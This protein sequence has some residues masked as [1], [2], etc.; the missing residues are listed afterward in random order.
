MKC[1]RCGNEF[2]PV[3][4]QQYCHF[5][6]AGLHDT[7]APNEP[8]WDNGNF[9]DEEMK[10]ELE[11]GFA[12]SSSGYCPWEDQEKLGFL[13]GFYLTLKE[14]LFEAKE[15]FSAMPRSNGFLLPLL[16]ALIIQT[17]GV[18]FTFFWAFV[19]ENPILEKV[20]LTGNH[21]ILAALAFPVILFLLVFIMAVLLHVSLIIVGGVK[22]DFEATF[23]VSCYSS[24]PE[25]FNLIPIIGGFI[26][27]F[28]KIYITV[29]GLRE[30]HGTSSGKAIVA[31]LLTLFICCGISF[32]GIS[33]LTTGMAFSTS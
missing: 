18:M 11:N 8:S 4:G 24:G 31:V 27:F 13:P 10:I 5:C 22:E 17:L 2:D 12:S 15:F 6:G 3:D 25:L 33:I 21:A 20:A 16:Y 26:A 1:P 14:S 30:V 32:M 7:Q 29:I 19:T 23:R 28:W 9:D